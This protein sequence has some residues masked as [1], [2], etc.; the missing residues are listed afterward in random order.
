MTGRRWLSAAVSV[1]MLVGIVAIGARAVSAPSGERLTLVSGSSDTD[2][3]R[4]NT[5]TRDRDRDGDDDPETVETAGD[6]GAETTTTTIPPRAQPSR[7]APISPGPLLGKVIVVDPGHNGQNYKY[8]DVGR[9]G[10]LEG[11]GPACNTAGSSTNAGLDEM[12]INWEVGTRLGTLLRRLGAEVILT[13]A[14]LDGFGPCADERGAIARD[15]N[16]AALIS[17]HADGSAPASSGFHIIHPAPKDTLDPT[18]VAA[19][20]ALAAVLRDEL[21][22][23]GGRAANYVGSAGVQER[24]D[25]ANLNTAN[26]PA[27][28]AEL[29]N[30][31]NSVDATML[32]NDLSYTQIAR[33][34][35]RGV[36]RFLGAP[37]NSP[38]I[39]LDVTG[40]GIPDLLSGAPQT[41]TTTIGGLPLFPFPT[42]PPVTTPGGTTP[43]SPTSPPATDPPGPGVTSPP[44][45]SPPVTSP[46]STSPPTTDPPTTTTEATTTTVDP[47]GG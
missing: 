17:I 15:A 14:D 21:L 2:G 1:A 27:I 44:A 11:D 9:A 13:H 26:R 39:S 34:L 3:T 32:S 18:V 28:L 37:A 30:L 23:T 35:A 47:G 45:T 31:K 8:S 43:T 33:A 4:G 7:L 16:A 6:P 12:K 36:V 46:P 25:L 10:S 19:S 38:L 40:D 41:T 5:T 20:A 29:G 24:G 22:V 42:T